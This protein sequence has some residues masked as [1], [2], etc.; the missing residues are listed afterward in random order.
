MLQ[1]PQ[2]RGRMF[3]FIC[4][5]SS[6]EFCLEEVWE[7][8]RTYNGQFWNKNKNKKSSEVEGKKKLCDPK[9]ILGCQHEI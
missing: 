7:E 8:F 1:I 9:M 4:G 3:S 2:N 5:L 6:M